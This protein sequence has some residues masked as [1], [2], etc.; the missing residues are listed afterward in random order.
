M[1]D[2]R[3]KL[4][5]V[6]SLEQLAS[7]QTWL[8]HRHT[9]AKLLV[10][11]VYIVCVTSLER[12]SV[13]R[14]TPFLLYPV[15]IMAAADIPVK[16]ILKRSAAA[17]PFCVFAGISGLIIERDAWIFLPGGIALTEG[18]AAFLVLIIRTLLCVS[19]VLI[20]TAI[21]PFTDITGQLRRIHI[22]SFFVTLFEMIY[23]YLG[24]LADEVYIMLTAYRL[25]S[26]GMKWPDIR[27][28]GSFIGQLL[29]RSNDRAERIYNA[30]KCRGYGNSP[31]AINDVKGQKHSNTTNSTMP[32]TGRLNAADLLFILIGAGTSVLFSAFDLPGFLGALVTGGM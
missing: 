20:M 22:P 1:S 12:H 18:T 19:A 2:I 26:G 27:H 28:A 4:N 13:G 10:T 5:E 6:Y 30:M 25:R 3:S 24:V 8:H 16:M 7:G 21:T 11:L 32:G 15:M 17:L 29:L 23:R 9:A 14:L 31:S